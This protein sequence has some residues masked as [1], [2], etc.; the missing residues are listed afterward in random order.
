MKLKQLIADLNTD[1]ISG[2]TDAEI[3]GVTFDSREVKPGMLFVAIRGTEADGHVYIE[4]AVDAGAAAIVYQDEIAQTSTETAWI[5]VPDSRF[6]LAQLAGCWYGHPSKEIRLTGVTGT[7]G[8]TT[9]ATLLYN[10]CTGLGYK[11]GLLSTIEIRIAGEVVP[12][13]HTTPDP[14]KINQ[15]LRQMVD[16]GCEFCFME[17]SSHAASQHRVAGL[18]FELAIFTN[19]THDH[20]DYHPDFESYI[21]AK[22][23]FFDGLGNSAVALVNADDRNAQVMV[24]NTQARV[25]RYGMNK[26]ADMH[27][28]VIEMHFAGMQLEL[29]GNEIWVPLTGRFNALNTLAVYAALVV[30]E[31]EETEVL[32]I[33]SKQSPVRGRFET[34]RGKSERM[35]IV[36]YA[37]TDDAL[38]NVL[39]T[40]QEVNQSGNAVITVIGAGGDRDAGKRPKMARIATLMSSKVILTSDNP[41]TE[42]PEQII[43]Q[44]ASGVPKDRVQDVLQ[45]VDREEAIK[46]A[47]MLAR[48][49]DI[50]LVAGKG[51][52]TIQVIGTAKHEFDDRKVLEKYIKA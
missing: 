13:T 51:H 49:G 10:A 32:E 30:L 47:C 18:H 3:C 16:R 12:A 40:I 23:S 31:Q 9:V 35:G 38:K 5:R 7:N 22:K 44:M 37:H 8:K 43:R 28:K 50:I 42:N 27:C 36:D 34:I 19:I 41:R 20:L 33:L 52:E 24:Q 45:I 17:V 6:A 15:L 21:R 25:L 26:M 1:Q 39:E 29:D 4:K 14:I 2:S 11:V 48:S 46:T